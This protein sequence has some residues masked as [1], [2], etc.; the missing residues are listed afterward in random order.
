MIYHIDSEFVHRNSSGLVITES[1]K[2]LSFVGISIMSRQTVGD[3]GIEILCPWAQNTKLK[4]VEQLTGDEYE[5]VLLLG[6]VGILMPMNS[7]RSTKQ[8]CAWS[9]ASPGRNKGQIGRKGPQG[10]L[11]HA[12]FVPWSKSNLL[13]SGGFFM[14]SMGFET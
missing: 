2:W 9:S 3:V 7:P 12:H 5:L 13:T 11:L 4:R 8:V 6:V 10:C 1:Q 14:K